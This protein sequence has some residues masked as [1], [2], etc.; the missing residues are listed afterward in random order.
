MNCWWTSQR[1]T[2]KSRKNVTSL[3]GLSLPC[4]LERW[5]HRFICILPALFLWQSWDMMLW[6]RSLR[7]CHYVFI[8]ATPSPLAQCAS[9]AFS[10]FKTEAMSVAVHTGQGK[11]VMCLAPCLW[12]AVCG[13]VPF[14]D[15]HQRLSCMGSGNGEVPQML[16]QQQ[17]ARF[18][19]VAMEKGV[20]A[21]QEDYGSILW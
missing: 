2:G 12:A 19:V 21:S 20:W 5:E 8:K 3:T 14:H 17:K 7:T 10:D 1:V 11:V 6:V 13:Q 9:R 18:L 4:F 16:F 15:S